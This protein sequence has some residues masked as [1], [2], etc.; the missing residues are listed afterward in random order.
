MPTR[1]YSPK[2][3]AMVEGAVK[4][5]RDALYLHLNRNEYYSLGE[6][7]M[8]LKKGLEK[9]NKRILSNSTESRL[10]QFIE[11]K[12]ALNPLPQYEFEVWEYKQYNVQKMGYILLTSY[13]NYYSVPYQYIGKQVK[14]RHNTKVVECYYNNERIALHHLSMKPNHYTTI[15]FH[16]SSTNQFYA[17]WCPEKFIKMATISIGIK[18]GKYVELMIEKSTYPETAYRSA[19]AI[20]SLKKK[21]PKERIERVSEIA[22]SATY[23]NCGVLLTMLQH[24]RDQVS[25]DKLSLI[26]NPLNIPSHSN[27]RGADQY[28]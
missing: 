2:D 27:I 17:D 12:K 9:L 20:I 19:L 5:V 18:T 26:D 13:K 23:M 25:D 1:T 22:M 15:H 4:I 28:K 8:E 14:V 24:N 10:S 6:L 3:K 7:N 16:L 11:E 21:F